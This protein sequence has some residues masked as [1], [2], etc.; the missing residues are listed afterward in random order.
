MDLLQKILQAL[1]LAPLGVIRTFR[2]F[3]GTDLESR[4]VEEEQ[5]QA[6]AT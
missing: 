1:A 5:L 4:V 2:E 6:E 3:I